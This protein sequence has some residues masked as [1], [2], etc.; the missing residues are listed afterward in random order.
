[1][2]VKKKL[3]KGC[4]TIQYTW[5]RGCCKKCASKANKPKVIPKQSEKRKVENVEYLKLRLEFLNKHQRCQACLFG[6][7]HYATDV[8][9]SSGRLG[10]L[11]LDTSTWISICRSCHQFVELH[12]IEA[13]ELGLSKS[14]L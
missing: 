6:C 10:G 8:H 13:K 1:M 4:G 3:C 9:H 14:R 2:I 5:A 7:S 11:F 12:P